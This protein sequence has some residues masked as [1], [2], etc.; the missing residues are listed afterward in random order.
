MALGRIIR[1]V[2]LGLM[3]GAPAIGLAVGLAAFGTAAPATAA[4]GAPGAPSAVVIM[5]HRFGEAKYPSTN[6]TLEQFEAHIR[7]LKAGQ[8][9]VLPLPEI[10]AALRDGKSLPDRTVG[11]TMD[12]AYLSIYTEAWPRLKEAGFPFTVFV[13]TD[14]IDRDTANFMNWD[15][16]REMASAG[17]TIGGH[18]GSHLHMPKASRDGNLDELTR[19]KKRFEEMLGRAPR[20]FAYP[21][22]ES[23]LAIQMMVKDAGFIAGFGQHSGAFDGGTNL[24]D[25]PR[26]AMNEN[27]AGLARFRLAVNALPLPITDIT[28]ADPLITTI[29]P[30]ALGFTALAGAKALDRLAC[31]SSNAGRARLERLGGGRIEIRI[32]QAFP[33]GRTRVNCTLPAGKGRWYWFGR[34]FYRPE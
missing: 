28:P 21:Y 18:T 1:T 16:V 12:D 6:I 20:L 9:S 33:K 19:S 15:Q 10:I 17:V 11:L 32:E 29:N 7:E 25:L 4:P 26:F 5:Y 31:F 23:S 27:Y 14:P 34:Q 8:Y 30:P 3:A 2:L 13:A 22:G 24:F